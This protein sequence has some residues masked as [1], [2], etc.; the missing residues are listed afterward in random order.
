MAGSG[1]E[2]Q[3][4]CK[5]VRVDLHGN[6][7]SRFTLQSVSVPH[8]CRPCRFGPAGGRSERRQARRLHDCD[9]RF[10]CGVKP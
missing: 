9:N 6:K 3:G 4:I 2:D 8:R 1:R 5:V 7:R 10:G